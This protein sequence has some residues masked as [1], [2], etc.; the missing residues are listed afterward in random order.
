MKTKCKHSYVMDCGG[1]MLG[2]DGTVIKIKG[3]GTYCIICGYRPKMKETP[4]VLK[5]FSKLVIN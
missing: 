5:D 4:Q 1:E 2:M 3:K